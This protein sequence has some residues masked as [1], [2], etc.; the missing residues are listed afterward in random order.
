MQQEK[1]SPDPVAPAAATAD[2]SLTLS[3]SNDSSSSSASSAAS[4]AY[5]RDVRLFPCLFCNKKFLKS[6]ALGGHQNAHKKERGFG[7]NSYLYS[8]SGP[9]STNS[10]TNSPYA[11]AYLSLKSSYPPESY[12]FLYSPAPHFAAAHH[13]VSP[14]TE[15]NATATEMDHLNSQKGFYRRGHNSDVVSENHTSYGGEEESDGVDISLR[16]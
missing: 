16:L 1:I 15:C 9:S 13:P 10:F 14:S 12:G 6:Q 8:P 11:V 3:L 5:D 7:V 2:L 4:N